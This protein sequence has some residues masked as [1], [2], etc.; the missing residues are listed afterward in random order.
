MRRILWLLSCLVLLGLSYLR[1]QPSRFVTSRGVSNAL[2]RVL[3]TDGTLTAGLFIGLM[4]DSVSLVVGGKLQKIS[5]HQMWRLTIERRAEPGKATL[6][7]LLLGV[8]A[9]NLAFLRGENEPYA[10]MRNHSSNGSSVDVLFNAGFALA[11]A[12]IGSLIGSSTEGEESFDFAQSEEVNQREWDRLRVYVSDDES[13]RRSAVH[14]SFQ[15]AWVDTYLPNSESNYYSGPNSVSGASNL[16]I[17]RKMQLAITITPLLDGGLAVMWLGQPS[18]SWYSYSSS[19]SSSGSVRMTGQGYYALGI[20]K[21]LHSLMLRNLQWDVG[22]GMG[23]ARV[24]YNSLH[25]SYPYI[26][27]SQTPNVTISETLFSGLVYTEVKLFL[28]G[29]LSLGITG[30]YV[31]I[32][33]KIPAIDERKVESRGMGTASIGFVLGLHF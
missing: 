30:D 20:L 29:Y 2:T 10:F 11:G 12:G 32:P 21:P 17:M 25:F 16:N 4:E 6:A 24:E 7:G 9:G 13:E 15:G 3:R 14:I 18:S 28:S 8:Y 22:A 1:S 5:R 27:T 33:K 26:D 23:F 31:I 19:G